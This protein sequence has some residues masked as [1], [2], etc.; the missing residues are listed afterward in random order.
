MARNLKTS[1]SGCGGSGIRSSGGGF[2]LIELVLTT[3]IVGVVAAMA[4]PRYADAL[5]RYHIEG[6]ARRVVADI[7]HARNR[8]EASSG[9][10][11][12]YFDIANSTIRV[13]GLPSLTQPDVEFSTV[14]ADEPYH[15]RMTGA[16]F[17]GNARLDFNGYGKPAAGGTIVLRSGGLTRT[18][19]VDGDTGEAGIQ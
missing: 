11:A 6:A 7:D 3:V 5:A 12:V 14:L 17:N 1:D 19:T 10:V 2:S 9:D 15:T 4:V 13:P 16:D 8:A 18:I